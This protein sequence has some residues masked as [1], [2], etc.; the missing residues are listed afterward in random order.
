MSEKGHAKNLE[1]LKKARD[2]ADSW[3]TKYAPTNPVI[4]L[5]N[6]NSVVSAADTVS[7]ALQTTIIPYRHATAAAED[8]FAPL[9]K[10][11]TRAM[12]SF[13]ISGVPASAIEDAETYARK[14]QGKRK[15]PAAQDNP[16]TA[17]VDESEKSHSASQMSRTQRVE[18]LDALILHFKSYPV[19]DPNEIDLK[20][21]T[22]EAL[23]AQLKAAIEAV[24]DAFVPYSNKLAERDEIYYAPETGLIYVGRLFKGYVESFGR[25]SA[26]WNQVKDLKFD[27]YKR[28]G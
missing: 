3:K 4:A 13:S 25:D 27:L 17:D 14:I 15:T 6:M 23:S 12:K 1:N 19:Y 18:N 16:A 24:S 10:L 9:S 20:T 26:E 22:L 21:A 2:F 7:D 11:I 8:L 28:R 5:T